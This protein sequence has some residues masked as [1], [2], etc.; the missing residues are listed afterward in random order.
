M[1]D[2]RQLRRAVEKLQVWFAH[3]GYR[4]DGQVW[5]HKYVD[6]KHQ[7]DCAWCGVTET[8]ALGEP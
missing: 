3:Q 5:L 6:G 2:D 4:S 1:S 7:D 8:L